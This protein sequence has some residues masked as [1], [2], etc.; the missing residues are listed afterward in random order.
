MLD[1][2]VNGPLKAHI[3]NNRAKKIVERFKI[4][5]KE[6]DENSMKPVIEQVN[7]KFVAPKPEM[8]DC[9]NDLIN[10]F[11]PNGEFQ[12]EKFKDECP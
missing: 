7:L 1:L 6:N 4:F 2:V 5:K 12:R 8:M 9:I 10:L 11:G 3:R